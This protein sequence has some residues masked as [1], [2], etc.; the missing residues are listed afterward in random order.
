MRGKTL[1]AMVTLMAFTTLVVWPRGASADNKS[2]E[3]SA[4]APAATTPPPSEAAAPA[5]AA[6]DDQAMAQAKQHFETGRNAYN[7][8]DYVTAI[9]EFKAAEGLRPSPI[10]DYNIGLA[11]EKLGKRRVAVKYYRRYLELQPN[12]ANKGEVD[13]KIAAL[14]AEIASQP[15]PAA[16]AQPSGTAPQPNAQTETA[17]DMPPPDPNGAAARQGQNAQ[18]D[19]YS[20]TAPPGQ[21]VKPAKKKS[22]W[23]IWLVVAGGVSLI[24]VLSVVIYIY[25]VNTT[26]YYAD[27]GLTGVPQA[28]SRVDKHDIG[29]LTVL[30]W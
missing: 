30:R 6:S 8:G 24:V 18:Y 25:A 13:G 16:N 15:P 20:G 1:V 17:S 23:W 14:E 21:A 3:K 5:A 4:A 2:S 28:P 9:R 29:G 11:N 27:R 7:A 10:L 19:P 12:A 22:L 26:Y